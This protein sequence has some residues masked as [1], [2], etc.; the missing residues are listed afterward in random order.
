MVPGGVS[1]SARQPIASQPPSGRAFIK[2]ESSNRQLKG[3][4]LAGQRA[5]GGEEAVTQQ[6]PTPGYPSSP[7]LGATLGGQ[8]L[9]VQSGQFG[10]DAL[11]DRPYEL[12]QPK[13]SSPHGERPEGSIEPKA[14]K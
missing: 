14:A 4:V 8:T 2:T 7:Q 1:G 12:L 13:V 5:V 6:S 9:G 10:L 11:S 3:L